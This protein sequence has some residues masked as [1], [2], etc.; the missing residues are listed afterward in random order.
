[1]PYYVALLPMLAFV[2]VVGSVVSLVRGRRRSALV[3]GLVGV[4][5]VVFVVILFYV[6]LQPVPELAPI[7][8]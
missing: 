3:F 6:A 8:R 2:G 7:M 5:A 1:M 4:G